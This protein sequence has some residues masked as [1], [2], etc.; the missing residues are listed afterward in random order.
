MPMLS[1]RVIDFIG[2]GPLAHVVT[3]DASGAPHVSL[4]WVGVEGGEVVFATLHDQ[5]KLRNIRGDG[6]VAISFE[7]PGRN[8]YGLDHYL[9]LRGTARVT[10]GWAPEKLQELAHVYLG[11]DVIF[12]PMPDP[13]PGFVIRVSVEKISGM[14]DWR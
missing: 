8:E 12:P 1:Q 13:P 10:E 11:P 3:L 6:R 2:T 4:A 9:V 7:A 5:T 14:G